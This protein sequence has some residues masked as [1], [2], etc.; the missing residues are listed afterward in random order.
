MSAP[1]IA[2]TEEERDLVRR[3]RSGDEQAFDMFAGHYIPALTRFAASR[4]RGQPEL[5][6]DI[7][8]ATICQAIERLQTWRGEATLFTWL[9]ACCRNEIGMHFRRAVKSANDVVLDETRAAPGPGP[10][11]VAMA[12]E[13]SA[14]V[15]I[16]LDH[17][18]PRYARAL[19]WKYIDGEAVD[20]IARRL[21]VTAK[22]AESVLT[23]AR[24]AFRDIYDR[25]G[26]VPQ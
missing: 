12:A 8:Q 24:K 6:R 21:N 13:S 23:R 15:H 16:A 11:E 5:T 3:M 9:C 14:R 26:E 2:A 17:L 4:L 20:D 25:L 1:M 19:E 7:V 10:E 22:A 18:P